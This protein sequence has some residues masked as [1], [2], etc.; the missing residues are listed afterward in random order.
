MAMSGPNAVV[1]D[2]GGV[3]VDWDP[4]HLYRKLFPGDEAAMEDFLGRVCTFAWH[5]QLDAGAS[6]EEIIVPLKARHP[7]HAGLI[8]IYSARFSE[9][10]AGTIDGTVELLERLHENGVPLYAL[11][12]WPAAWPPSRLD[13]PFF[14]RFRDVVVSG[15]EKVCKPDPRIFRIL[16]DRNGLRAEETVYVDDRQ[17]NT[18]AAEALGMRAVRFTSPEALERDLLR[19]GLI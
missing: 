10:F 9:M 4:R 15:V 13:Y 6:F 18:D 3:L 8:D 11:T 16:L 12:N 1:F 2:L 17:D 14:G 19:F 5:S 7:E